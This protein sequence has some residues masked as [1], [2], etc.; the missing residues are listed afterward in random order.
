M[1]WCWLVFV[2]GLAVISA[3]GSA[4]SNWRHTQ[5][6]YT[7][8]N[9]HGAL[10]GA[11]R[12]IAAGDPTRMLPAHELA[13][14]SLGHM[15]QLEGQPAKYDPDALRHY[16]AAKP[17]AADP[18]ARARLEWAMASYYGSTYRLRAGLPHMRVALE[19]AE[20]SRDTAVRIA[21]LHG[22]ARM[23]GE[24][25]ELELAD[26]FRTEALAIGH[27]TVGAATRPEPGDELDAY[28][29][30]L[31]WEL[32]YALTQPDAAQRVRAAWPRMEHA[33]TGLWRARD[34]FA[35]RPVARE[36]R[37][38]KRSV[39]QMRAAAVFAAIGDDG[40]ARQLYERVLVDLDMFGGSVAIA[41]LMNR[42]SCTRARIEFSFGN[43]DVAKAQAE[44]CIAGAHLARDKAILEQ[45]LLGL[46]AEIRAS[47]GD[48]RGAAELYEK[49]IAR[50]EVVRAAIPVEER[51]TF[52]RGAGRAPWEGLVRARV[53][54]F[55]ESGSDD[56]L[57]R[58]LEA[59]DGMRARQLRELSAA[60]DGG[61]LSLDVI[62]D[63]LRPDAAL[64]TYAFAGHEVIVVAMTSRA[65]RAAVLPVTPAALNARL[66]L[67]TDAMT[68]S[69][70]AQQLDAELAE[71]GDLL[72]SAVAPELAH[73]T[74][75]TVVADG[76]IGSFPVEL[77]ALQGRALGSAATV[78]YTP[79]VT[80]FTRS[81]PR[82]SQD[83]LYALG[84]P[85][86]GDP[87][88]TV[89][90]LRG[91]ELTRGA[92]RSSVFLSSF[93]PLP[94][95]RSEVMA[96]AELFEDRADIALGQEATE[97][98]LRRNP[99]TAHRY[100]HFATHGILAGQVP[101]LAEPAL[102]LAAEPDQDG[103][104]TAS[105]VATMN[106]QADLAVLSAC[107]TGSG[108]MLPGEGV[109][110][111]GRAFLVAGSR[112]VL[113][114]LWPVDSA[115]TEALIVSFYRH[116]R[117][118]LDPARALRQAKL[119]IAS[120]DR[121]RHPFFW[122]AFILVSEGGLLRDAGAPVDLLAVGGTEHHDSTGHRGLVLSDTGLDAGVFANDYEILFPFGPPE[123]AATTPAGPV[124]RRPHP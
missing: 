7:M 100:V 42:L 37:L 122:S 68:R 26:E 66:S 107:S 41:P 96:I 30:L 3:C 48:L 114:S 40:M 51:A 124:E 6:A 110:G 65:A 62:R 8:A 64:L 2:A 23:L 47:A 93:T 79:S 10:E 29:A 72:L 105:E 88:E 118:G 56:A 17:A 61:S 58:L 113:V 89:G 25:G 59:S 69:G 82:E 21:A 92:S 50:F 73:A 116:H 11:N 121:W 36:T 28:L 103:F 111:M 53:R 55:Q 12:E 104:L 108:D 20:H 112:G 44:S 95:T 24:M 4:G 120:V 83:R 63:G 74:R 52:F 75:I 119:D 109:M 9:Y 14:T 91:D 98:M 84:D 38:V 97:S 27:E 76:A 5:S 71:L 70:A 46:M 32:Q 87:P 18:I 80:F 13:I 99:P 22:M 67:V 43:V 45:E 90:Y 15:G 35:L 49:E 102:V 60:S 33:L 78:A 19:Q 34:K 31:D 54:Q 94:E 115:A 106:L 16:E 39:L 77:L 117:A 85:T 101:G 86:Y 57:L 81:T 123:R 1:R